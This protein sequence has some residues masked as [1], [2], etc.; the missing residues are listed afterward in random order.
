[1]RKN[2]SLFIDDMTEY[3]YKFGYPFL[4]WEIDG[5]FVSLSVKDQKGDLVKETW[6]KAVIDHD[7]SGSMVD[8]V[9]HLIHRKF[10]D[11]MFYEQKYYSRW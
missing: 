5:Q 1:M 6:P 4:V 8:Y 7:Y 11:K 3:M 9:A 2:V 10:E